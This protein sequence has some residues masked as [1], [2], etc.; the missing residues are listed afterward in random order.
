MH[1]RRKRKKLKPGVLLLFLAVA[2]LLYAFAYSRSTIEFEAFSISI[3]G[4]PEELEGLKIAH[5]SDIHGN[6]FGEN[7]AELL[8]TLR[9]EKPDIIALTGDLCDDEHPPA[10]VR[11]LLEQ[12]IAIAPVYYVTGNH[13]WSTR[14][15]NEL[16]EMMAE[17]GITPLRNEYIRL[18]EGEST[19]ILAGIDDKNGYADMK[20]PAQLMAEI[21]AAEGDAP[22]VLLSHRP[23]EVESYWDMGYDLVFAGHY[24]GGVVQI[25]KVGGLISPARTLFPE[26]SKGLYTGADGGSMI[27]SA[28]LAGNV[29]PP[30]LFNPMHVPIVILTP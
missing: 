6:S 15:V 8:D 10:T 23:D 14:Q 24:H 17:L 20:T 3:P 21:R 13:E 12:L 5:L 19:L 7:N 30:R 4:L 1:H 28:G 2:L 18:G 22:V 29:M 11:P 26:Y 25:P 9:A 16:T 27:L